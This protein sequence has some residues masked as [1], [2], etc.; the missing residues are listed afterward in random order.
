M[1]IYLKEEVLKLKLEA[2][3]GKEKMKADVWDRDVGAEGK[4]LLELRA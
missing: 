1:Y 4:C 3:H 2:N